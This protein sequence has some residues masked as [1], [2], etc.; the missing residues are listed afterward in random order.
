MGSVFFVLD[1]A[2]DGLSPSSQM[3][4]PVISILSDTLF[5]RMIAREHGLEYS[6]HQ[7]GD[8]SG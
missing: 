3:K 4:L 5:C 2:S 8:K 6:S 7:G 1:S